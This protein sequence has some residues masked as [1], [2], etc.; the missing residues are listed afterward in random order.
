MR[1]R[2]RA[3]VGSGLFDSIVHAFKHIVSDTVRRLAPAIG[4]MFG[5]PPDL[6]TGLTALVVK[7]H[8]GSSTA[9]ARLREVAM[10]GQTKRGRFDPAAMRAAIARLNRG[11]QD[12]PHFG[13]LKSHAAAAVRKHAA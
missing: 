2:R 10:T 13:H 3:V 9:R 11:V 4:P 7:A 6:V 5:L 12:H 1:I 8:A